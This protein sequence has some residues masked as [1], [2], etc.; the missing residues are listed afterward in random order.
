M[1][2]L[3]FKRKIYE[4]MSQWKKTFNGRRALLIKGARR[5][6][7]STIV[8]EFA[9]KEYRSYIL[10]NFAEQGKDVISLFDDL[11]DI[12][13]IMLRLQLIFH[14]DLYVRDSVIIFD[15]VQLCP[16]ARQAIKH[17]VLDGRYDYIETGSLL[18]L[19]E[20]VKGMVI[21]SEE[22]ILEMYPMDFEEFC[23]AL[24]DTT[25]FGLLRTVFKNLEAIGQA[26][27]RRL[28]RTFRLYMLVGGMP[29]SVAEYLSTNNLKIVDEVKREIIDL[30]EADFYKFDPSGR[31]SHI[32]DSI[33]GNLSKNTK[34]FSLNG[35]L[36]NGTSEKKEE[37]LM[38]LIDSCTVN[39]AY[40]CSNPDP[41]IAL[42]KDMD[43]YK[44]F[45][46]DTGLFVT[47]AFKNRKFTENIIYEKLLD[48][49]LS[50]NLGYVYENMVA[51]ML[52]SS[53]NDLF[54]TTFPKPDSVHKYEIDF[55]LSR[56][57]KLC[58][59]EVKSGRSTVHSSLDAFIAKYKKMTGCS[60]LIYPRDLKAEDGI[61][62]LPVFMAGL[63]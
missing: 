10:I 56:N 4:E 52:V 36:R 44:L 21:P 26:A 38:G 12:D 8:E 58:P 22:K 49:K 19:R 23:W 48:D 11:S 59:I 53:G 2:D 55:L 13:Y 25:T 29:Q 43:T 9:K 33:P 46:A 17:L 35:V 18:T 6:G 27:F 62:Y 14:T 47:L 60:Y 34:R 16:K 1:A 45:I 30:Y 54:Y 51:Q 37:I 57:G 28:I 7:K 5:V 63:L 3:I 42:S 40:H 41:G 39:I 50:S 32:F 20:S 24:S 31:A 15:E 61:I